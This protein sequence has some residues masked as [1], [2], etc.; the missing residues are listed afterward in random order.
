MTAYCQIVD[1]SAQSHLS[2]KIG[3][4]L[5]FVLHANQWNIESMQVFFIIHI[6]DFQFM[7][8]SLALFVGADSSLQT[9]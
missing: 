8:S 5:L 4:L 6:F 1:R 7:A 3:L 9:C 2:D